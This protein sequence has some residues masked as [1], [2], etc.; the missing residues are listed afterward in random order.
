MDSRF[1]WLSSLGAGTTRNNAFHESPN[2]LTAGE[3]P[4]RVGFK[5]QMRMQRLSFADRA[6]AIPEDENL[7]GFESDVS[8]R[9]CENDSESQVDDG[10]CEGQANAQVSFEAAKR[11]PI[12]YYYRCRYTTVHKHSS[13]PPR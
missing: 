10:E 9:E 1:W 2:N 4:Y 11:A 3:S 7:D 8:D 6:V 12:G 13:I 5:Q